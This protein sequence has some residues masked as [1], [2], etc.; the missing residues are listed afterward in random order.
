M[1]WHHAMHCNLETAQSAPP[2]RNTFLQFKYEK[3]LRQI[4]E[5]RYLGKKE[6]VPIL[7]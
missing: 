3:H 6:T 5:F 7:K 2:A 1:R 4:S